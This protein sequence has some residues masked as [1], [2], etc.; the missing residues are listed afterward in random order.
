M[1]PIID[2]NQVSKVRD[3]LDEFQPAELRNNSW[4]QLHLVAGQAAEFMG[5]LD[6]ALQ[7]YGQALAAKVEKGVFKK[8]GKGR[9]LRYELVEQRR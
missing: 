3:M 7:K 8:V 9:S 2:K 5:D 6:G 4:A 1:R